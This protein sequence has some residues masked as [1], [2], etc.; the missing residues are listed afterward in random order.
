[1]ST[2]SSTSGVDLSVS[3]L[4]SGMDWK[5]IVSELASAERA[6]ETQWQSQQATINE[7]N[8]AFGQ[9][10]TLL[11]TLQTDVDA[12]KD[13]TLYNNRTAQS[14]NSAVA[15][16]SA[17]NSAT[18]GTFTFN[19]TQLATQAQ[20]N[21]ATGVA[22]PISS[23]S[24]LTTVTIGSAGFATPITAG[25]FTVNGKQ[26]T[27]A[28]TDSLQQVFDKISTATG[29][30]VTASYNS[31]P[32][33]PTSDEITL[34]SSSPIV[35]GS[36]TDT[37]NF[38]QVAQLYN[39]GTGSITSS[40]PLGSVLLHA[41]LSG[42]NL[43]TAIT[44]DA[45]GQGQ[46]TINGVSI[47]YDLST[48]T[49]Q[50]ILDRINNSTAGVTASYNTQNESF[51]LTNNSTGDVGIGVQDVT[52]NFLAATGLGSGTLARGQN[53]LYNLNGGTTSLVSQSNTI[54]QSSSNITGLSV[55]GVAKGS[56]TVSVGSDTSAVQT[57]VQNF[58][59]AYN[60]V[61]SYIASQTASTT[62]S[63]GNVTAGILTG[64][65]SAND[66]TS[67]LRSL[68]F[69]LVSVP[70]LP[71][72]LNQLADLG[73]QTNGQNNTI[74]L[75]STALASALANNPAGVQSLFSD[76]T[77]G[78]AVQLDSYLTDTV[79]DSGTLTQ[80]QTSLTQQSSSIDAQVAALEKTIT[81]DSARWTAEFQA[82]EQAQSQINQEMSYLSQ[83]ISNG[84][85]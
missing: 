81:D 7:Q 74:T 44:G 21:G 46:F 14:S 36:A 80:H 85:L 6:P 22:A 13:P 24:D 53:L 4:A 2:T 54:T 66:I 25:T 12:L 41:G 38:L 8:A 45:T 59:S 72:S 75:D 29:G 84:T 82:M 77:K 70:G 10:K 19:I 56:V 15:T 61:Q 47:S 30:G 60:S 63:S 26:V 9:I 57:A 51:V 5:T 32:G 40:S 43:R 52:G 58:V 34:T 20:L 33:Q 31:T 79:G 16:A 68:S 18:Q 69:G 28:T 11:T 3:G 17:A 1:M 67:S 83:Q 35:L 62:D 64:D 50:S 78:W 39:N 23:S 76:P 42:S 55:T 48:D 27:I 73:I 65:Q 71:S 49:I 37:S